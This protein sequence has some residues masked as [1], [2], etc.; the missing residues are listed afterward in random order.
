MD[1][2]EAFMIQKEKSKDLD[3]ARETVELADFP[4]VYV[5][6]ING[7]LFWRITHNKKWAY[8]VRHLLK[9]VA[10]E[11]KCEIVESAYYPEEKNDY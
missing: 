5:I 7:N 4:I 2:R 3:D 6:V 9:M 8:D 11:T 1:W 10:P